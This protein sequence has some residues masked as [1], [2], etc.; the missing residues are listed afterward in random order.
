[1]HCEI[2]IVPLRIDDVSP[3]GSLE[4]LV[5]P[6]HWI[7]ALTP[8]ME[9]HLETL[10]R[11][12]QTLLAELRGGETFGRPP[13]KKDVVTKGH[14]NRRLQP[15]ERTAPRAIP[16]RGSFR[17]SITRA[18]KAQSQKPRPRVPA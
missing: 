5:G 2:P 7:D 15:R 3:S 9:R 14:L 16:I 1:M 6:V 17:R 12:V 13:P 8:P 10:S 4:Y 11:V 18:L